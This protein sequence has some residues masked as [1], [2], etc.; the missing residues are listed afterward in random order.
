MTSFEFAAFPSRESKKAT[1][2][3]QEATSL[4]TFGGPIPGIV[5]SCL[6]RWVAMFRASDIFTE[7]IPTT[8]TAQ[9]AVL[10]P[11]VKQYLDLVDV[12]DVLEEE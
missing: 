8:T 3:F 9:L 12:V 6:Y 1:E 4:P 11:F 5:D 7:G 10:Y 2:S